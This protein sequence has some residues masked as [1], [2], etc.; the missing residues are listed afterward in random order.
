MKT[1]IHKFWRGF[2]G[3]GA[4]FGDDAGLD[5]AGFAP[6]EVA[7]ADGWWL[8]VGVDPKSADAP[9]VEAGI[10]P[11]SDA[12]DEDED[13]DEVQLGLSPDAATTKNSSDWRENTP[14]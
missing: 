9:L 12:V 2:T 5:C 10:P 13:E 11:D 4:A 1:Q 7:G 8:W 6:P 3:A 14:G